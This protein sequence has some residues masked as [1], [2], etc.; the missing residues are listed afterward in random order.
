MSQ[1]TE[2]LVRD[3]ARVRRV[4]LGKTQ[5][6]DCGADRA[7]GA[8]ECMACRRCCS[9]GHTGCYR[10]ACGEDAGMEGAR[11]DEAFGRIEIVSALVLTALAVGPGTELRKCP[12]ASELAKAV[13]A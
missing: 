7:I 13:R 4:L 1:P 11:F 12:A 6:Q 9:C 2:Q 3:A 10:E 5:C 8:K